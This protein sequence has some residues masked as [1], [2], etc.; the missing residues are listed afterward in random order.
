M[1]ATDKYMKV[2]GKRYGFTFES[3][4]Y[5][6]LSNAALCRVATPPANFNA[7]L[8]P[9]KPPPER[10]LRLRLPRHHGRTSRVLAGP[11]QFR[12]SAS[13]DAGATPTAN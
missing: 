10:R 4:N 9:P 1:T 5:V 12:A 13:A 6:L 11:L 2:G 7:F 8:P 3:S